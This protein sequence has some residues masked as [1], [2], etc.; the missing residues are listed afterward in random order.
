M[1]PG[2][3]GDR[4]RQRRHLLAQRAVHGGRQRRTRRG[5]LHQGGQVRRRAAHAVKHLGQQS[6]APGMGRQI[7]GD[8]AQRQHIAGCRA[9]PARR[10]AHPR[11][12]RARAGG[13]R[14]QKIRRCISIARGDQPVMGMANGALTQI[15]K[16]PPIQTGGRPGGHQINGLR[17]VKGQRMV[18]RHQQDPHR[19]I[20]QKRLQPRLFLRQPLGLAHHRLGQRGPRLGQAARSGRRGRGEIAQIARHRHIHLGCHIRMRPRPQRT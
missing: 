5:H 9:L 18:A 4:L 17:V 13:R 12:Q 19:H 1:P 8:I 10:Q 16:Q 6:L 2:K 11:S 15:I 14:A 20:R 7:G 3:L